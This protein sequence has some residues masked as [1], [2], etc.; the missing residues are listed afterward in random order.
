MYTIISSGVFFNLQIRWTSVW[1]R[2]MSDLQQSLLATQHRNHHQVTQV[3]I[4]TSH[5]VQ[6]SSVVSS[7]SSAADQI[8]RKLRK[9]LNKYKNGTIQLDGATVG[10]VQTFREHGG[11]NPRMGSAK[12]VINRKPKNTPAD[13]KKKLQK[14]LAKLADSDS[15]I[16]VGPLRPKRVPK[17]VSR[18]DASMYKRNLVPRSPVH[19]APYAIGINR[20]SISKNMRINITRIYNQRDQMQVVQASLASRSVHC[21]NSIDLQFSPRMSVMRY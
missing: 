12:K 16:K 8:D 19:Q 18:F 7:N 1:P 13:I 10:I 21:E 11:Y 5:A 14:E 15:W 9:Y 6:N 2:K 3:T 4:N 17:P 20:K